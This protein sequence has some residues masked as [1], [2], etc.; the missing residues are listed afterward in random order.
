MAVQEGYTEARVCYLSNMADDSV[1]SFN[2]YKIPVLPVGP[3]PHA[4]CYPELL[5]L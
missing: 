2:M 4:Q 1:Q 5:L 3:V